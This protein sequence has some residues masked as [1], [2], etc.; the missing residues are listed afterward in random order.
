MNPELRYYLAIFWRRLPLFLIVAL[1]VSSAAVATALLLPT[2][3]T[4]K[5]ELLV[6]PPQ[7]SDQLARST[8]Q[9]GSWEQLQIV[10]RRLMTRTN[11]LEI[12]RRYDVYEEIGA[13]TPDEIVSSMR[14]DTRFRSTAGRNEATLMTVT[15]NAR[16]AAISAEV[17]NEY[18]TRILADSLRQ[19]RNQTEGT[20]NFFEQEVEVLEQRLEDQSELI[21]KFQGENSDALPT[22]LSFRM[23]R[24]TMLQERLSQMARDRELLTDQRE[25]IVE[26]FERTGDIARPVDTP[27]TFE[28]QRLA[29]LRNR[30]SAALAVYSEESPQVR[31]LRSQVAS[32][33]AQVASLATGADV[34]G[35]NGEAPLLELQLAEIDARIDFL[36]E[37]I[38]AAQ[39]ELDEVEESI[40]RTPNN[41]IELDALERDYENLQR[42][43]DQAVERLSR[44]N[45]GE[46]LESQNR[47]ERITVIDQA[48][49]PTEPSKPNRP[50]IAGAGTAV[51]LAMAMALV[52]L[53][54]MMNRAIRR[55]VDLTDAL[56]ITPLATVPYIA[57]TGETLR[58]RFLILGMV[59]AVLAGIPAALYVVHYQYMPID[60]LAQKVVD[61]LMP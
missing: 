10:Q 46:R 15:F 36:D 7:I 33:E 48:V 44:A 30:L 22:N 18:V 20:K 59:V 31:S 26:I 12:A 11:L 52:L 61:R 42:Q 19:R 54:E 6:E 28:E 58:R 8:V 55:P 43:Y 35:V 40:A 21:L 38:G 3:Y 27:Q 49:P 45:T 13:M 60:L 51:G 47:G 16:T 5:A 14:A 53:M 37:Q 39:D 50:L 32:M 25:R 23:N 1:S 17:A 9:T 41:A 34:P 2:V 57:T 24:A 4:S 29:D 56:G